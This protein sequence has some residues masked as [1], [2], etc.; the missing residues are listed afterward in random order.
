MRQCGNKLKRWL[1]LAMLL[2]ASACA[3]PKQQGLWAQVAPAREAMAKVYTARSG[4]TID[5]VARYFHVSEAQL[6]QL[7]GYSRFQTRLRPGSRVHLPESVSDLRQKHA[8]MRETPKQAYRFDGPIH[9][10]V[11]GVIT[12]PFGKRW[13]R[14]HDGIDIGVPEGTAIRAAT[15]GEVAFSAFHGAYGN[16]VILRHK[17][18]MM[19]VYA[20]TRRILVRQ[21]ERVRGGQIIA[22]AGA[23]GRATGPH[24]HFEVRK[25]ATPQNP[26]R[27]LPKQ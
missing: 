22:Q 20:H 16:V 8:E 13:G 14:V 17:G 11:H 7:N 3:A 9:W 4:D 27:F 12:S 15:D 2:G 19:T 18:G 24:L 25:G 26:L 10:P 1:W 21:G 6:R 23:T 5:S